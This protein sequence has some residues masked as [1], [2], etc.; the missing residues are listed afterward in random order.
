[1]PIKGPSARSCHIVGEA[2]L[3]HA[4]DGWIDTLTQTGPTSLAFFMGHWHGMTWE[5]LWIIYGKTELKW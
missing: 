4:W 3:G 5:H 1:V 2:A